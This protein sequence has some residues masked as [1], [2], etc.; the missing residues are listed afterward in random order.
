M[1]LVSLYFSPMPVHTPVN[2][3]G[4]YLSDLLVLAG[5]LI[6]LTNSSHWRKWNLCEKFHYNP[7]SSAKFY[8]KNGSGYQVKDYLE[9][10]TELKYGVHDV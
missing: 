3:R 6:K 5:L 4:V 2:Q 7:D 8:N 1:H 9:L 10:L